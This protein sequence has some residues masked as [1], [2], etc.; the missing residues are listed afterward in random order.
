[1]K[2]QGYPD[3]AVPV[4]SGRAD[5]GF[6][7][8]IA[9]YSVYCREAPVGPRRV[10]EA[11][12]VSTLVALPVEHPKT[13]HQLLRLE[14]LATAAFTAEVPWAGLEVDHGLLG[15]GGQ[16]LLVRHS[17]GFDPVEG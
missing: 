8:Y 17:Q 11:G 9:V 12:T 14:E 2:P 6:R 13:G 5:L 1:M 15:A 16:V 7:E 4:M 10:E 3:C